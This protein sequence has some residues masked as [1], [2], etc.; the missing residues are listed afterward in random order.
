M[1]RLPP[2]GMRTTRHVVECDERDGVKVPLL[3]KDK[4]A[5]AETKGC[6]AGSLVCLKVI[7]VEMKLFDLPILAMGRSGMGF[8]DK[9]GSGSVGKREDGNCCFAMRLRKEQSIVYL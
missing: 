2:H 5:V 1:D 6:R 3:A 8:R 9:H 4:D 7:D